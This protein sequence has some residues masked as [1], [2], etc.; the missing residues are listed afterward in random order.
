[1]AWGFSTATPAAPQTGNW[2]FSGTSSPTISSTRQNLAQST[3]DARIASDQAN[4]FG[5]LALSAAKAL[6]STILG[7]SQKLIQPAEDAFTSGVDQASTGLNEKG[8]LGAFDVA[9]GIATGV[10][11]PL[12][13]ILSPISK[14]TDF[15]GDKVANIPAVQKFAMSPEGAKAIQGAQDE[16]NLM[17]ILGVVLGG[18]EGLKGKASPTEPIVDSA[19]KPVEPNP[20]TKLPVNGDTTLRRLSVT[21]ESVPQEVPISSKYTPSAQ[22]PTIDVGTTPKSELPTIQTEPTA[23]SKFG[24]LTI[25]PIKQATPDLQASVEKLSQAATNGDTTTAH[26]Q[27]ADIQ[28]KVADLT[29]KVESTTASRVEASVKPASTG[30]AL[31]HSKSATIENMQEHL[32]PEDFQKYKDS[33]AHEKANREEQAQKAANFVNDH[34]DHADNIAFRGE[35]APEGIRHQDVLTELKRLAETDYRSGKITL[36]QYQKYNRAYEQYGSK[37]GS[38]LGA[39]AGLFDKNDPA[40]WLAKATEALQKSD[41]KYSKEG[42]ASS[43]MSSVRE[44]EVKRATTAVTKAAKASI[45]Y[46]AIIKSITC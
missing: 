39:R 30:G 35:A 25:E 28:T 45:D 5:G 31:T 22:L 41:V 9:S 2:G 33:T 4:S 21:G 34:P 16:G 26:A 18:A 1:M 43:K 11:S 24:D 44:A 37:L 40:A 46:E 32:T 42:K 23:S 7:A 10:M 12:A 36:D 13:P 29:K 6:G 15:L 8:T 3:A 38:E 27:L 17:N 19:G 14:V 20:L